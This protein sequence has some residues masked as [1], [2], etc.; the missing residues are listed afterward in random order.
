MQYYNP[1]FLLSTLFGLGK[2][3]IMP[4]T[5]GSIAA[6]PLAY[7]AYTYFAEF[8]YLRFP[9]EMNLIYTLA[10]MSG[11]VVILFVLGVVVSSNYSKAI[12][13]SDPKE[14][15]IDEV[16]GQMITIILTVP[17]TFLL[18][19]PKTSDRII[20]LFLSLSASFV[21]FRLFDIFK[22]WPINVIDSNVKGGVGIMLDDVVAAIFASVVYCAV[23]LM[24]TN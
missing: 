7:Y 1:S 18:L 9:P 4:G 14:V 16:V 21:L 23:L 10:S 19:L 15:I 24:L 2:V 11:L 17:V 20:I 12:K 3:G 8:F 5:L 22:P 6:Y 13:N